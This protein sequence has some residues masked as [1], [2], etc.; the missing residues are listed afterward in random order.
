VL[1]FLCTQRDFLTADEIDVARSCF[2]TSPSSLA[3]GR[4]RCWDSSVVMWLSTAP[5][6]WSSSEYT[7]G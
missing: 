3:S 4:A 1:K 2:F 5:Q 6:F 7:A